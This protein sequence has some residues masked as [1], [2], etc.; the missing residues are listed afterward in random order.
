MIIVRAES[1]GIDLQI[2]VVWG[3]GKWG[4][5]MIVLHEKYQQ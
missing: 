3:L 4:L 1:I 5:L 2:T